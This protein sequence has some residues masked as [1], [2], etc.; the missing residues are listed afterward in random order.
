M[1]PEIIRNEAYSTSADVYAFGVVVWEVCTRRM[2]FAECNP[3]QVRCAECQLAAVFLR[4]VLAG[5]C[6][7]RCESHLFV[8]FT[9]HLGGVF[10]HEEEGAS[11]YF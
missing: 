2:P 5:L 6:M 4:G 11:M 9:G 7:R 1:A 3:V 8:F 10:L